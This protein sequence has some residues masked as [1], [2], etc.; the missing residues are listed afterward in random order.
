MVIPQILKLNILNI[1][2]NILINRYVIFYILIC[3]VTCNTALAAEQ[4]GDVMNSVAQKFLVNMNNWSGA[5]QTAGNYLLIALATISLTWRSMTLLFR[6]NNINDVL[7]EC[8]RTIMIVGFFMWVMNN[9]DAVLT[10][11]VRGFQDLAGLAGGSSDVSASGMITNG[12][13]AVSAIFDT[14]KDGLFGV[15]LS[16]D[17]LLK[18]AVAGAIMVLFVFVAVNLLLVT[19]SLYFIIYGGVILLA[20][21]GSDWTRSSAL[22]YINAILAGG[23]RYMAMVLMASMTDGVF[24]SC[25]DDFSASSGVE[26]WMPLFSL[27]T[28]AIVVF[29]L[30]TKLPDQLAALV[31][32]IG[33]G[34]GVSATG[35]AAATGIAAAAGIMAGAAKQIAKNTAGF[36]GNA[37]KTGGLAGIKAADDLG[38]NLSGT[39]AA[40]SDQMGLAG[41]KAHELF[42]G[43]SALGSGGLNQVKLQHE[44]QR[45]GYGVGQAKQMAAQANR[46]VREGGYSKAEAKEAVSGMNSGKASSGGRN[47]GISGE[48]SISGT[49]RTGSADPGINSG[50]GSGISESNNFAPSGADGASAYDAP[51]YSS[52]TGN[53]G[54]ATGTN[55][56]PEGGQYFSSVPQDSDPFAY[57]KRTGNMLNEGKNYTNFD[58]AFS[59]PV[60]EDP[61]TDTNLFNK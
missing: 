18:V 7:F 39:Y 2:L 21:G 20:L 31:S 53:E 47:A 50:E 3:F 10:P 19:V 45:Q 41:Q 12:T 23:I 30:I 48:N 38:R 49:P 35:F 34:T 17:T 40:A 58:D 36:A 5:F 37:A 52:D 29:L 51:T 59:D 33:S 25:L 46:M 4:P 27:L 24:Q 57:K 54:K 1:I 16:A 15:E 22:N 28:A 26:T 14:I 8:I 43:I 42:G 55:Q 6:T 44:F 61:V 11:I 13:K 32:H 56:S 60:K 9:I